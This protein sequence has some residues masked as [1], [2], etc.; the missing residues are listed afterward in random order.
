MLIIRRLNLF[1]FKIK[2]EVNM[3]CMFHGCS[4]EIKKEIKARYKKIKK[5]AFY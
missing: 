4:D 3:Q 1:D 2:N 5:S